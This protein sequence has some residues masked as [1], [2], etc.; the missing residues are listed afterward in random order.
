MEKSATA[1][2]DPRPATKMTTPTNMGNMQMKL[3]TTFNTIKPPNLGNICPNV[4]NEGSS[5]AWAF[6]MILFILALNH[7]DKTRLTI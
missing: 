2:L 1:K 5:P 7:T 4:E 6:S 3:T